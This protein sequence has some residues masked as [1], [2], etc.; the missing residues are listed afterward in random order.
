MSL[1]SASVATSCKEFLQHAGKS[2][3]TIPRSSTFLLRDRPERRWRD[4]YL[5]G[6]SAGTGH[7]GGLFHCVVEAVVVVVVVVVE[8][9]DE[10]W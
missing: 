8:V 9:V 4:I 3:S 1:K 2:S 6:L 10:I 5:S 7:I